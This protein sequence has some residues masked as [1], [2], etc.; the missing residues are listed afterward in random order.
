[1]QLTMTSDLIEPVV[2][3]AGFTF[4]EEDD[5]AFSLRLCREVNRI[6]MDYQEGRLA[7]TDA[8]KAGLAV[9]VEMLAVLSQTVRDGMPS[10]RITV[11]AAQAREMMAV[12]FGRDPLHQPLEDGYRER[13]R[14][15]VTHTALQALPPALSGSPEAS[16]RRARRRW[17]GRRRS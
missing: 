4:V 8:V 7:S 12:V 10:M 1:V 13:Y 16:D 5:V 6:Y 9:T 17:F 14:D 2:E 11:A 3:S 15:L